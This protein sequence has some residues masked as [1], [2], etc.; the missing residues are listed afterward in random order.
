ME[1][2]MSDGRVDRPWLKNYDKH[3]SPGLKYE[4]KSFADSFAEI[5][6]KYPNKTALIYM[7]GALTFRDVDILSNQLAHYFIKSICPISRHT[8][9]AYWVP[10]RPGALPRGYP[11]F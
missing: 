10:R 4:E 8:I 5:V 3:V 2:S 11:R 7:G 1:V 6:A 9:L